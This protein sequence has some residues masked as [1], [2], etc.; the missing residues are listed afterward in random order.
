MSH[1]T[2]GILEMVTLLLAWDYLSMESKLTCIKRLVSTLL[3]W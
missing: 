1:N 2:N 3:K